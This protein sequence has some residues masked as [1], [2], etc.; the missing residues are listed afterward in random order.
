MKHKDQWKAHEQHEIQF[1]KASI[2]DVPFIFELMEDGAMSGVFADSFISRWGRHN[3]L[4]FILKEI[5]TQYWK[6][7]FSSKPKWQVILDSTTCEIGFLKVSSEKDSKKQNL[8]LLSIIPFHRNKGIGTYVLNKLM[9]AQTTGDVMVHCTKYARAM[10]HI[11]KR[12]HFCRNK[13][14]Q[15]PRLEQYMSTRK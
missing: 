8:E 14:F 3:L 7:T 15:G 10:Q 13:K 5:I 6:S 1:R 4:I 9:L 12:N 11:L 2:L